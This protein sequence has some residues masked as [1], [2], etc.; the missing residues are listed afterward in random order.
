MSANEKKRL[1]DSLTEAHLA[2]RTALDD[3]DLEKPVYEDTGWRVRD[4]LGHI[5]TWDQVVAKSLRA[6]LAGSEYLVPNSSEY[7]D[8]FNE[9]EVLEQQKMSTQQILDEF[10][11]AYEEFKK[12]IQEIP[13]EQFPGD[14]LYPWGDERGDIATMVDYMIE[15]AIEHRDEIIKAKQ[16]S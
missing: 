14:L 10:E 4:I 11:T 12:A 1:I 3:V 8:D 6:Y 7:E 9:S 15:H 13:E 16:E 2:V 5:A